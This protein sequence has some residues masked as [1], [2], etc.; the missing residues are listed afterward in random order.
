[1]LCAVFP[2]LRLSMTDLVLKTESVLALILTLPG[3]NRIYCCLLIL[4]TRP[5]L[6]S[7]GLFICIF[8][9]ELAVEFTYLSVFLFGDINVHIHCL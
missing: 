1:M 3:R 7:L 5:L 2:K 9:T 6:P 8:P 4:P